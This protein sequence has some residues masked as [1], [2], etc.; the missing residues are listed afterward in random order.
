M[1]NT[2][3]IRNRE[4]AGS[5]FGEPIHPGTKTETGTETG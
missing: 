1:T 2:V 3:M 5:S 4:P